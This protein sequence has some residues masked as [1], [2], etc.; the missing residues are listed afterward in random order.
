M[1]VLRKNLGLI[2]GRKNEFDPCAMQYWLFDFD[3]SDGGLK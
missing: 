2:E 1:D 3:L